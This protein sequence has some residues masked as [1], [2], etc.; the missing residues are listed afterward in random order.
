ML[1]PKEAPD[2]PIPKLQLPPSK[3]EVLTSIR[4]AQLQARLAWM[5]AKVEQGPCIGLVGSCD[6]I[7]DE[8][9][10]RPIYA[11]FICDDKNGGTTIIPSFQDYTRL[12]RR[13][14]MVCPFSFYFWHNSITMQN[15]NWFLGYYNTVMEALNEQIVLWGS[16]KQTEDSR[17]YKY[18]VA[19]V[20]A[21]RL[22]H[23]VI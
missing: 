2:T 1:A 17:V 20:D 19:Y 4:R 21:L 6:L 23:D 11:S 9:I 16:D 22:L 12:W 8:L 3:W 14:G 13:A 7:G 10:E 15:S 18:I 5:S